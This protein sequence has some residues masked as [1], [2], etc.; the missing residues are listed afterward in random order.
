MKCLDLAEL[1]VCILK[2]E[3]GRWAQHPKRRQQRH[4]SSGIAEHAGHLV[5]HLGRDIVWILTNSR[6]LINSLF[7]PVMASMVE[8][9]PRKW[10]CIIADELPWATCNNDCQLMSRQG[11]VNKGLVLVRTI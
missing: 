9:A 3:R 7:S 11:R 5:L 10:C 6:N 1:W 8:Y 4:H 2:L